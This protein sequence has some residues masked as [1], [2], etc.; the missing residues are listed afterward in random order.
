MV[1]SEC[2]VD[3]S[4]MNQNGI[5]G[6]FIYKKLTREVGNFFSRVGQDDFD[7]TAYH[8]TRHDCTT[9]LLLLKP[10]TINININSDINS[11][12]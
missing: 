9:S 3:C 11:D 8:S 12:V 4:E 7:E 5:N 6:H 10:L 1:L 2:T